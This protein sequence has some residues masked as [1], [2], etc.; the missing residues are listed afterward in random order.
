MR[1]R[2]Q[3]PAA[4]AFQL[5]ELDTQ[6]LLQILDHASRDRPRPAVAKTTV[7]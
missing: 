5:V 7:L 1:H 6:T 3:T 2:R 4:P